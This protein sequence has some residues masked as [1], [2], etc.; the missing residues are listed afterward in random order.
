MKVA[1]DKHSKF[2]FYIG[3]ILYTEYQRLTLPNMDTILSFQIA[4]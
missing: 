2:L 1:G 3:F 4:K